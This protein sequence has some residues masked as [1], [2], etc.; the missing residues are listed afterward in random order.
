MG[1]VEEAVAERGGAWGSLQGPLCHSWTGPG[2]RDRGFRELLGGGA[3]SQS[4]SPF[5]PRA[6]AGPACLRRW[7]TA[8]WLEAK[9]RSLANAGGSQPKL[10]WKQNLSGAARVQE[11]AGPGKS[12]DTSTWRSW[13]PAGKELYVHS[14]RN[15]K[16]TSNGAWQWTKG[17]S[18]LK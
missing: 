16:C 3:G 14:E 7:M 4:H 11:N 9:W 5:F 12:W 8:R 15:W 13:C 1:R 17:K 10:T 18:L 6:G 2:P